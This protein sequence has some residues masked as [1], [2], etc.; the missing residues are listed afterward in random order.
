M[1]NYNWVENNIKNN[2]Y[3]WYADVK[4]IFS[5]TYLSRIVEDYDY[6]ENRRFKPNMAQPIASIPY[7]WQK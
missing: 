6:L 5:S 4:F 2:F 7:V 3:L 1:Y